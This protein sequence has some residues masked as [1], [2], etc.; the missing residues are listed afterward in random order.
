L[1]LLITGRSR[2]IACHILL[3]DGKAA[4]GENQKGKRTVCPSI[5]HCVCGELGDFR[6]SFTHLP[7]YILVYIVSSY[8]AFDLLTKD[9]Q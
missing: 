4:S 9:Y 2:Y 7:A 8:R 1:V 6:A 5:V 3:S